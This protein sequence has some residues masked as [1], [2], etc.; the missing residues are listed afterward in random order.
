MIKTSR[1][2]AVALAAGAVALMS[3]KAQADALSFTI[4]STQSYL[5]LNIPNFSLSGLSISLTAQNRTNGAPA[6]T[7]WSTNTNTGNT[8]FVTGSFATSRRW[9]LLRQDAGRDPVHRRRQQPV[10]DQLGQLPPEPGRVQRHYFDLQQQRPCPGQLRCGG[11][12]D[13][14]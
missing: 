12:L 2:L 6:S 5:T 3:A 1:F 8:A 7:L 10:G 14:G 11:S 13:V 9:Q 4:D